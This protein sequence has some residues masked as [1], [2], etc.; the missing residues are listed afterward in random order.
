MIAAAAAGA[1][2]PWD[3]LSPLHG[4]GAA[5]P[6]AHAAAIVAASGTSFAAGM[7]ILPPQR[8]AGMH[9]V[10]AFCRVID[11]IADGDL[12]TEARRALLAAWRAEL[13][14]LAQGRPR[15]V[16]GRALAGPIER[17]ALPMVEFERLVEGMSMDAEGPIVAPRR[18]RLV[19][20]IRRVAGSV[21]LLSMRVFGAWRG[22]ASERF[23]LALAEG[24]Q[25]V[26]ILR[27][28][29]EDAAV[30][31][32]Y[33]P[34]ETLAR[35]G[36]PATPAAILR[37]GRLPDCRAEIGAWAESS[38]AAA[39]REIVVHDRLSLAPALMMMG[40]YEGYLA[41]MRAARWRHEGPVRLSRGRKLWLGVRCVMARAR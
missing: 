5:D 27:D 8:R 7:R 20:Y 34:A 1:G 18:D 2:T 35:A 16:L 25:L 28:V 4:A 31:R 38:F 29:E 15:S 36:A 41:T 17:Y 9:A 14:L 10:Y 26:N 23:A 11:D 30:G 37:S 39:R 22:E 21:G 33:L 19:G 32:L 6:A 24:L 40:P 3:R 12:P 13:G